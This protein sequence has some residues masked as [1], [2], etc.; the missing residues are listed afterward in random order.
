MVSAELVCFIISVNI[1]SVRIPKMTENRT[2]N[3]FQWT[4]GYGELTCGFDL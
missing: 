4:N 2:P 3:K 1:L